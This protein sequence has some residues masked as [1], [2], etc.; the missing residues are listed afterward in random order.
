MTY[1]EVQLWNEDE[2]CVYYHSVK[3]AID[4][5]DARDIIQA[6]YP[7]QKVISVIRKK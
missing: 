4:Y 6:Q 2:H 7:N 5:E 1:Y 3:D